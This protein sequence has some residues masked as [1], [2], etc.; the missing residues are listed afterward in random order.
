MNLNINKK[1]NIKEVDVSEVSMLLKEMKTKR[2]DINFLEELLD[3]LDNAAGYENYGDVVE[4]Y[5]EFGTVLFLLKF[6]DA[7]SYTFK[8]YENQYEVPKIALDD[9]LV[10]LKS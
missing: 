6:T 7:D 1:E 2:D 9:F 5:D 8:F 4:Y 3:S 10:F